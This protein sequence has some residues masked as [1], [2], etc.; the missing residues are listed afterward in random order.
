MGHTL[1]VRVAPA[2]KIEDSGRTHS[3]QLSAAALHRFTHTLHEPQRAS[4]DVKGKMSSKIIDPSEA[5][6]E[7]SSF[8]GEPEPG[9]Q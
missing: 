2:V 9:L 7:D 6:S 1:H 3:G 5:F 4:F 8:Y